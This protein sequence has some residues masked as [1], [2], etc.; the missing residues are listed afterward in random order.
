MER[1]RLFFLFSVALLSSSIILG[2]LS[3]VFSYQLQIQRE[4]FFDKEEIYVEHY[5]VRMDDNVEIKGLMYAKDNYLNK[6]DHSIPMIFIIF[7]INSRKEK[8]FFKVYQFLDL[9]Y[10]VFTVELRGHGE[11]GGISGFLGKEP[12]DMVKVLDYIEDNYK[13]ANISHVALLGFS[14]G[15]GVAL[16]LQAMDDRIYASVIYHPLSSVKK[17][18]EIVPFQNIIGKTPAINDLSKIKDGYEVCNENNTKNL[19][20]IHGEK[21]EVIPYQYSQDVY[22]KLNGDKRDDLQLIIRPG[23]DHGPNEQDEGSLKYTIAWFEHFYHN[24]SINITNLDEEIKN[25]EL[26]EV[27]YP[28][29]SLLFDLIFISAILLFFGLMFLILPKY[30]WPKSVGVRLEFNNLL[31][32]NIEVNRI[33]KLMLLKRSFVYLTIAFIGAIIFGI[34]NPSYLYGYFLVIPLTII[35]VLSFIKS[36]IYENWREEWKE[37]FN[38]KKGDITRFLYSCP[39]ILIPVFYFVLIYNF[40]AITTLNSPIPFFTSTTLIY[41]AI[42]LSTLSA[43]LMLIRNLK[44]K[45]SFIIIGLRYA[46]LLIFFIFV[47]LPEFPYFGQG[48]TIHII[49]LLMIG[50]AMWIISITINILRLIFKNKLTFLLIILLPLIIFMVNRF[51]RII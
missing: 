39:I 27:N 30:L 48:Y 50:L 9:G 44:F 20:L 47:P 40:E 45:H 1:K 41:L 43:D 8:D 36:S 31:G 25:I 19:L 46:S 4:E 5:S 28:S 49:L 17:F 24:S 42:G 10:A 13:F 34:F 21:D 35:I 16:I 14:Y 37:W 22:N 2:I 11:S 6:K 29:T 3:L 32:K 38:I 33:Y 12:Q 23:L 7:G 51:F 18:L 15:G 26:K